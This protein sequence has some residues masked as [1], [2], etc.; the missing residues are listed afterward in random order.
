MFV[1]PCGKQMEVS[2]TPSPSSQELNLSHV[3]GRLVAWMLRVSLHLG[4]GLTS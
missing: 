3:R 1:W 2:T 4:G